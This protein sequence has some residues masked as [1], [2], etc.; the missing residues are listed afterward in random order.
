MEWTV[1]GWNLIT[2]GK[3]YFL[4]KES[5][6]LLTFM[7]VITLQYTIATMFV[8]NFAFLEPCDPKTWK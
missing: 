2:I 3:G 8:L 4:M 6:N 5:F 7:Q 1:H